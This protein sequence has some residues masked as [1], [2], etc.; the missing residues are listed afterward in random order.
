MIN[1]VARYPSPLPYD[2]L[3][4]RL[5]RLIDLGL[6]MRAWSRLLCIVRPDLYCTI[7]SG[8]V[9]KGLSK[10]F[11]ISQNRLARP[12]GYVELLTFIHGSPWFNSTEPRNRQQA[13]IWR[14]RVAFLDAIFYQEE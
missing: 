7:A 13:A 4:Q 1:T 11:G 2:R 9:R 6:T 14:R 3:A 12:D 5:A 10:A 8:P